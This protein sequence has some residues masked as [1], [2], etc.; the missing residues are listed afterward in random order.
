M[1]NGRIMM[2]N[3]LRLLRLGM[4][5]GILEIVYLPAYQTFFSFTTF[6]L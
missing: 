4:E 6:L 2:K 3:G 5:N 1:E